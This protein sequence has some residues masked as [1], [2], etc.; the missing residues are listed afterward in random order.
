MKLKMVPIPAKGK[1]FWM[2][3][4]KGEKGRL[5][6]EEQHEVAFSRDF[7]VGVTAVTQAQYR[8]VMGTNPSYFR[9]DGGGKDRCRV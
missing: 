3:S 9:K 2:G 7:Y 8:A 4:P 6:D 5:E 1:T